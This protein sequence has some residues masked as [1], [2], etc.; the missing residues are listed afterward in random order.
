MTTDHHEVS[1]ANSNVSIAGEDPLHIEN[2]SDLTETQDYNDS[3]WI[4]DDCKHINDIN[5]QEKFNKI[6]LQISNDVQNAN[7][8]WS[9]DVTVYPHI[10]Y[11]PYLLI[12]NLMYKSNKRLTL[13]SDMQ[14]YINQSDEEFTEHDSK[15]ISCYKILMSFICLQSSLSHEE[16][17]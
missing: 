5:I 10:G 3:S 14:S 1:N 16:S 11:L 8:L 9:I 4:N 13:I 17:L 7:I 12:M 15:M 6:Y 2:K